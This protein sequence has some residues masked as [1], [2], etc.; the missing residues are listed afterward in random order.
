MKLPA[1]FTLSLLLLL[2]VQ[3]A[4]ASPC[5]PEFRTFIE[6]VAKINGKT[7]AQVVVEVGGEPRFHQAFL[8]FTAKI[9]TKGQDKLRSVLSNV[10]RSSEPEDHAAAPLLS[11]MDHNYDRLEVAKPAAKKPQKPVPAKPA[12]QK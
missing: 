4:Q 8:E 10:L 5:E 1:L 11:C 7:A 2:S 6:A 12:A 9:K 3:A